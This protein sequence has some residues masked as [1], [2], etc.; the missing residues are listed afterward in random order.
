MKLTGRS[1]I[2][3]HDGHHTDYNTQQRSQGYPSHFTVMGLLTIVGSYLFVLSMN[4]FPTE[5]VHTHTVQFSRMKVIIM[6][7]CVITQYIY[8]TYNNNHHD[9]NHVYTTSYTVTYQSKLLCN[10]HVTNNLHTVYCNQYVGHH[11][12]PQYEY[13]DNCE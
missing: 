3:K 4:P 6:Y 8:R 9:H 5:L 10:S 1:W 13:V 12:Y 2:Q 7:E 11:L